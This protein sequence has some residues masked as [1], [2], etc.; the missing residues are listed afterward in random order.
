M[1]YL[2]DYKDNA[3]I[4]KNKFV[5]EVYVQSFIFMKM[6]TQMWIRRFYGIHYI[7][8]M[9]WNISFSISMIFTQI[10]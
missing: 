3:K 9:C 8:H 4:M 6:W 7:M 5:F 2:N 1:E 10:M